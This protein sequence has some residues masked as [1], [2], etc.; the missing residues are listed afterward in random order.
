MLKTQICVTRPQCVKLSNDGYFSVQNT[1]YHCFMSQNLLF[2]VCWRNSPQ[3][4]MASSFTRFLDH[5]QRRTTFG[6]TPLDE[7]SA[8]RRDLYLTTHNTHNRQTCMPPAGF[9]HTISAGAQSYTYAIDRAATGTGL[10]QNIKI[11][12]CKTGKFSSY[13]MCLWKLVISHE[14]NNTG[15]GFSRTECR[16]RFLVV[17]ERIKGDWRKLRNVELHSLPQEQILLGT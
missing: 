3:W 15:C 17:R 1:L 13:F 8:R 6:S 11:K 12:L 5:T 16:E 2:F 10:S 4:A 7:W 14:G 9:E